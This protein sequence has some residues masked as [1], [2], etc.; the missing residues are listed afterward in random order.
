MLCK[1]SRL[2]TKPKSSKA[3]VLE[4]GQV[5][6]LES[7]RV[8]IVRLGKTLVDYKHFKTPQQRGVSVQMQTQRDMVESL[9]KNKAKLVLP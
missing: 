4:V 6:E 3:I 5:W 7:G 2:Q 1:V 9:K 8:Q